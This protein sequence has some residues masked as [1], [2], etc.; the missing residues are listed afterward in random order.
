MTA[1]EAAPGPPPDHLVGLILGS[2]T[3]GV[4]LGVGLLSLVTWGIRTLQGSG[5]SLPRT[6]RG[7]TAGLL[8]I[9]LAGTFGAML[10]GGFATWKLLGAIGNPWR[11]AML[12]IVAG[13]GSFVVAL[14]T[15]PVDRAF[16]R[17]GLL[18]LAALAAVLCGL[19]AWRLT[20]WRRP[21]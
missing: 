5:L 15:W 4:T 3:F 7:F 20:I 21:A 1:P 17:S 16:G 10:A 12:G 14:V 9:V 11:K 2:L 6:E 18:V 19:I 13:A 8:P